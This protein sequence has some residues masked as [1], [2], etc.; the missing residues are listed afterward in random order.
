MVRVE[1]AVPE[2]GVMLAGEKEQL[3]VLGTPEHD[4]EMGLFEAPDCAFAV[5]VRLPDFPAGIVIAV[6]EAPR[7]I[8]VGGG[9]GPDGGT[10]AG[11]VGL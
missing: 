10:V 11:H 3:K 7:D 6:G 2:P 5:T 4:S 8:T 9:G 1:V